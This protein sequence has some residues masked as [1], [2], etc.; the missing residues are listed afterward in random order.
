[1]HLDACRCGLCGRSIRSPAT[2]D[3]CSAA[4]AA[5]PRAAATTA[6][7]TAAAATTTAATT[8]GA[9]TGHG[10]PAHASGDA[11]ARNGLITTA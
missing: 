10:A 11:H 2:A 5:D 6:T 8:D 7:T 1:V 3:H 4:S 9:A